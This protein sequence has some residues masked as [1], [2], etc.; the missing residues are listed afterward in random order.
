M[1][2]TARK[3][4]LKG[5]PSPKTKC[6]PG[7]TK[8]KSYLEL[9]LKDRSA[10]NFQNSGLVENIRRQSNIVQCNDESDF[11]CKTIEAEKST[12]YNDAEQLSNS[13]TNSKNL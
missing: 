13:E 8:I 4:N 2:K 10:I 11:Q 7:Q 3:P 12:Q 5:K 1:H 9:N 6:I